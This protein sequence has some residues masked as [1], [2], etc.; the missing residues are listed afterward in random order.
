[1]SEAI[2]VD[3]VLEAADRIR[4]MDEEDRPDRVV[5]Q[6]KSWNPTGF[7]LFFEREMPDDGDE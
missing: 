2:P 3:W 4:D 7:G 5:I 6:T 1:M